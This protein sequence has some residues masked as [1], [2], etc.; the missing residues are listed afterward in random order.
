MKNLSL[1]KTLRI[2][3]ITSD[4]KIVAIA[5]LRQQNHAVKG[6]FHYRVIEPLDYETATDYTG[7]IIAEKEIQCLQLFFTYLYNQNDWDCIS[8]NDIPQ[9]SMIIDLLQKNKNLFPNLKITQGAICPYMPLPNSMDSFTKGLSRN[10]RKNLRKSLRNLEKDFGKVELKEYSELDSLENTM[11]LFFDLHQ[12]RWISKG[13]PGAFSSQKIR[14]IFMDRAILFAE[15]GWLGLYFLTVNDT[16]VAA[17]YTLKYDQKVY[18]CLS[19]LDPAY[20]SYRVGNI[21]LLKLIEKCIAQGIKE[22][23]FMKGDESYKS[24]WT[25]TYRRNS[26]LELIN[27]SFTSRITMLGM[28]TARKSK[29]ASLLAKFSN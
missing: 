9:T 21:A 2:L 18:G 26:N 4:D 7:L 20:S 25:K 11:Q 5:P 12:K 29:I 1:E 17:R 24:D 23:D 14:N 6:L 8:F 22:Y 27:Q 3:C 16:P 13:G 10:L 28:K 19:G 15:K